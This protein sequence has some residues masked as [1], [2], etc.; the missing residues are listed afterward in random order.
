M[1]SAPTQV[2][3]EGVWRAPDDYS[4]VATYEHENGPIVHEERWV[5]GRA[6]RLIRGAWVELTFR[7]PIGIPRYVGR[8]EVPILENPEASIDSGLF[9]AAGHRS[10][11]DG[12]WQ[13]FAGVYE[14]VVVQANARLAGVTLAGN[15]PEGHDL[16]QTTTFSAYNEPVTIETPA[17]Y[18]PRPDPNATPQPDHT[19]TPTPRADVFIDASEPNPRAYPSPSAILKTSVGGIA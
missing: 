16:R 9:R 10:P 5:E 19:P 1:G 18:T 4:F 14:I 2:H 15:L 8:S 13:T 11:E 6:L 12:D 3:T 7:D 17:N